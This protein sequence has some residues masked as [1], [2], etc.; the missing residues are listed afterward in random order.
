LEGQSCLLSCGA[1]DSP[2]HH[3]TATVHVWC[4]ISFHTENSRPL[5][6][7]IGWRTG[8][9]LVCPTDRWR[10]HV[11]CE[12]CTADR[13]GGDRWLTEQ[14]GAPP[15]SP[16]IFSRTSASKPESS[17]FTGDQPGAPDTVRYPTGQSVCL[18]SVGVG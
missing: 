18:V 10:N 14:S 6:L 12:D 7:R 1:P 9:C 13:C 17:K 8:H 2:V 4:S 11:S 3:R 16:M 15:D 5:V